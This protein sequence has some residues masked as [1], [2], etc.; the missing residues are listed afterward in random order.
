M[1]RLATRPSGKG[2]SLDPNHTHSSTFRTQSEPA[3]SSE[4][5]KPHHLLGVP[6]EIVPPEELPADPRSRA[7]RP[8]PWRSLARLLGPTP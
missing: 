2:I 5:I 1:A 4:E 3:S 7:R 6:P 8:D